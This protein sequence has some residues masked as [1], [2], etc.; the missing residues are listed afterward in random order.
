MKKGIVLLAC[1]V[2]VLATGA[3]ADQIGQRTP[4]AL[5]YD[6]AAP[7]WGDRTGSCD[8]SLYSG[9][10]LN[11][12]L[13]DVNESYAL[14][15]DP[16][17]NGDAGC[18]APFYPF[19]ITSLS[20]IMSVNG[21]GVG[22]VGS[23]LNVTARVWCPADV[24]TGNV[25]E[26]CKGPG[27][28]IGFGAGS[29]T[30]TADDYLPPPGPDGLFT[31]TVPLD[32]CVNGPF[33]AGF[34]LDSWDGPPAMVPIMIW[35]N[36]GAP[37]APPV[38][39]TWGFFDLGRGACWFVANWDF[40]IGAN[41]VGPWLITAHGDAGA[42]C[43]PVACAPCDHVLPGETAANPQ[44]VNGTPSV[45]NLD[46]C[47]YCSDYDFSLD[48][49]L[50][51]TFGASYTGRGGDAVLSIVPFADQP[52][53]CLTIT[54]DPMCEWAGPPAPY[55]HFRLRWWLADAFGTYASAGVA[56]FGFPGFGQ[57]VVMTPA[58]IGCFDPANGPFRLYID[59][60]GCCCPVRVTVTGDQILPVE[61]T[62]FDAVAGDAQVSLRWATA[63]ER[64][65]DKFEI[66]RDGSVIAEVEPT[67]AA[68]G[69]VY[70]YV[71]N[72]VVNGRT[73]TYG[74]TAHDLNGAMTSYPQTESVTPTAV[75][76]AEYALSQNYPNPF[77]PTT[78]ISYAVKDAG[79]VK[80]TVFTID[81]REVATL[82]NGE[83]A[84]GQYTVSFDGSDLASGVYLYTLT[85]NGFSASHKMVLMK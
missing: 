16:A 23:T 11:G 64:G 10:G 84:T 35:E 79:L 74:L 67:N 65:L 52:P 82:V 6:G 31:I 59:T 69:H 7:A 76:V 32:I 28:L 73:Y 55:P 4:I 2:L 60:R 39:K 1:C 38:C 50:F 29:H 9:A 3:W 62:S 15:F 72:D 66:T 47:Q 71:D 45:T 33:F 75:T 44:Q 18:S 25:T 22:D 61:F 27:N 19:H 70:T 13:S 54:I 17:V 26:E 51:G 56:P 14:Y 53:A 81:G 63:S 41:V 77:N 46:L 40:G 21:D 20:L 68:T 78:A 12:V 57:S 43:T 42:E 37:P 36:L 80:L 48:N 85:V 30:V 34:S 83:L 24:A 5:R 49:E 58:Q 8:L